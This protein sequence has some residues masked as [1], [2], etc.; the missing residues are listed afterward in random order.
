MRGAKKYQDF[1][2]NIKKI[3]E[4]NRSKTQCKFTFQ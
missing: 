3:K 1:S 2:D 4:I